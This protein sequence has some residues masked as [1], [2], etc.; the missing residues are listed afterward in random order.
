MPAQ[1]RARRDQPALTRRLGQPS[2]QRGE[3][4]SIRP[5]QAR[6]RICSAQHSDLVAQDKQLA[7]LDADER[8]SNTNQ[9]SNRTK[10]R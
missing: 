5:I 3:H 2:D 9:P 1:D 8:P 4:R 7:S 6:L 10:I